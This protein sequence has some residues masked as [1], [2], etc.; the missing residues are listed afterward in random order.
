VEPTTQIVREYQQAL[1]AAGVKEYNFS[2]LEGFIVAKAFTEGLR[3]TGRDLTR[4]R[5]IVAL[6]SMSRTDLGDFVVSFSP[7]N[8]AG[9]ASSI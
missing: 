5:L 7:T 4:E 9:R 6:E 3:R 8:R 2:S 1:G